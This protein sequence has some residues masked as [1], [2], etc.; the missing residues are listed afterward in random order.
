MALQ[1]QKPIQC[2]NVLKLFSGSTLLDTD[3][4]VCEYAQ[5]IQLVYITQYSFIC[6]VHH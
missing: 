2:V 5:T 1:P 3:L 4:L 6:C